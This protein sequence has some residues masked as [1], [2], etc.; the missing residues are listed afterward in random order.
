MPRGFSSGEPGSTRWFRNWG[1]YCGKLT[2]DSTHHGIIQ[3]PCEKFSKVRFLLRNHIIS[4]PP[5]LTRLL[6][7]VTNSSVNRIVPSVGNTVTGN[8]AT[9]WVEAKWNDV[10][11]P[12][13]S[14][15]LDSTVSG[16]ADVAFN[17][18]YDWSD[19]MDLESIP[20]IDGLGN[21][22]PYLMWRDYIAPPYTWWPLSNNATD[23]QREDFL[24]VYTST[25]SAAVTSPSGTTTGTAAARVNIGGI[26]FMHP[27]DGQRHIN[28]LA[29][30]DSITQG[31]ATSTAFRSW[32]FMAEQVMK[33]AGIPVNF[34]NFGW[35][36]TPT[37][38][39]C[40]YGK[41]AL[42]ELDIDLVVYSAYSPNNTP[43]IQSTFDAQFNDLLEFDYY[44]KNRG[45]DCVFGFFLPD[46]FFSGPQDAGRQAYIERVK[47]AF[48]DRT[49]D[50]NFF[51][52]DGNIPA[53]INPNY[54]SGDSLHAN[55]AGNDAEGVYIGGTFLRDY[56][57]R[58]WRIAA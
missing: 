34:P 44:C 3:A 53:K 7:A 9:G 32:S 19:W 25:G 1:A 52:S 26:Q 49:F 39:Y 37:Y 4:A 27:G 6:A 30:G 31:Y 21:G 23:Q 46:N 29:L 8:S 50:C 51:M 24:Q 36:G 45:V 38:N 12:T 41:T 47:E 56:V 18:S 58:K 48:P 16:I 55:D 54:H 28:I 57:R 20:P 10:A 15:V 17:G 5:Q 11:N 35:V 40:L 13:L 2:G 33:A 43:V 42:D 14:D 22:N